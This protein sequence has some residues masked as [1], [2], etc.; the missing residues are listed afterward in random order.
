MA[1][2]FISSFVALLLSFTA[3]NAQCLSNNIEQL[4]QKVAKTTGSA[5]LDKYLN[6]EKASIE[7]VF[8]V[9]VDMKIVDDAGQPN[10]FASPQ[11]R[12]AFYFD[13]SVFLGYALL[14]EELISRENGVYAIKGIMA[15]EFAHILQNKLKCELTGSFRELHAD[16]LAGYYLGITDQFSD[17]DQTT[18]F[19]QSLFEKGDG[20]LWEEGHH[21]TP[22][23]RVQ[24][25]MGGYNA[26]IS[27]LVKTPEQAYNEGIIL[28]SNAGD[29]GSLQP[30]DDENAV[31]DAAPVNEVALRFE[32]GTVYN[33]VFRVFFNPG[34]VEYEGILALENGE[35]VMRLRY[36]NAGCDCDQIV[37][38][39][40]TVKPWE[41]GY[42]LEGSNPINVETGK[43]MLN[44][45]P[46]NLYL[47]LNEE[48]E[49]QVFNE[50][51]AGS[52]SDVKVSGFTDAK[53]LEN[54]L[55]YLKWK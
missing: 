36:Y 43:R 55:V 35:G 42:K 3:L 50:D 19:A 12:N 41:K 40:I 44:Y 29:D 25:M 49:E 20:A 27:G 23:M 4:N 30:G 13:G 48:G 53:A 31:P 37:E 28:F 39:T 45:N 33:S 14:N 8:Q 5:D 51:S 2:L 9:R 11:S 54:W 17:S 16:F 46:D 26:V 22:E 6:A 52:V 1:Q 24:A 15:H 34:E 10:A 18:V 38:Q 32:D 7:S 21:G 47:E